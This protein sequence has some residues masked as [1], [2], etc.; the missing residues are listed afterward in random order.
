[1]SENLDW[2]SPTLNAMECIIDCL[3]MDVQQRICDRLRLLAI[4][5]E[6]KKLDLAS[7]FSRALSGEPAPPPGKVGTAYC[8]R[9]ARGGHAFGHIRFPRSAAAAR[10]LV[11][12]PKAEQARRRLI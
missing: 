1:M 7:Y 2:W 6:D 8:A 9:G 10:H 5:Q 4:V 3:P 12:R 11:G